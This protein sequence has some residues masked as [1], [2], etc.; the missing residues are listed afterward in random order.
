MRAKA[1]EEKRKSKR[2]ETDELRVYLQIKPT[3][4]ISDY[5]KEGGNGSVLIRYQNKCKNTT[6]RLILDWD[7]DKYKYIE[8]VTAESN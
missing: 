1:T 6:R 8:N 2:K 5:L 7:K 3:G 4:R